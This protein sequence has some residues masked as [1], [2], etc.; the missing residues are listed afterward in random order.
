MR[1]I[2]RFIAAGLLA[3]GAAHAQD[4]TLTPEQ[5]FERVAPSI[6]TVHTFDARNQ[7]LSMG[8]AVVVAPG[9]LVTNCHVLRKA[10]AVTVG[11]EN[12]SYKASL[13]FP[14][15]ERDLCMLRVRSLKAPAVT[16]GDPEAL[17]TGARVYAI[18]NPR[19][20]EQTIS[21][22]LLSGVRRSEDGSFMALQVT[23]P[24]SPGSSG[25]GLFD[26]YGRLV[27]ITTFQLKEG[28]NLN[29]ALPATWIA[30]VPQRAQAVLAANSQRKEPAS[31]PAPE[32]A[33]L[34]GRVFEYRL[35]DRITHN[36][37][38]VVYHVDRVDGDRVVFN[39]GTRVETVGGEVLTHTSALAGEADLAM[40]PGGWFRPGAAVG[41]HWTLAY[42]TKV[43]PPMKMELE[44][45]VAG[46]ENL[47]VAGREI[48]TLRIEFEG[49]TDRNLA[50]RAMATGRY[51]ATAWYAPELGRLVRFEVKSRGGTS[52]GQYVL[53]ETLELVAIR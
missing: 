44:A 45:S 13:E 19:G 26:A 47:T 5:L 42:L 22:G 3:A 35:T 21:D 2:T 20:L 28:Q 34:A 53:E 7:P 43:G 4:R 6:W 16:I 1:D 18:G 49:Y 12:V 23:V 46:E 33:D 9:S 38:D 15:P 25:G 14:D 30:Q 48:K 51:R 8:S 52:T 24:I 17:K 29:F 37:Q 40:P 39:G 36:V 10:S 32:A 50:L 11:R 41:E 31:A 27:G